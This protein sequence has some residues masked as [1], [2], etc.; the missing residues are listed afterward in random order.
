MKY[1]YIKLDDYTIFTF[2]SISL[3]KE[4]DRLF[5]AFNNTLGLGIVVISEKIAEYIV[6]EV[7]EYL[8]SDEPRKRV[9]DLTKYNYEYNASKTIKTS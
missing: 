6:K 8:T 7:T 1:L 4:D 3:V 5:L 2:K 9:L